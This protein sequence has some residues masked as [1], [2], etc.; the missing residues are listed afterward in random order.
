MTFEMTG[1]GP[2]D[3]FTGPYTSR[4]VASLGIYWMACEKLAYKPDF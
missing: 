2:D 1:G 3:I 4:I